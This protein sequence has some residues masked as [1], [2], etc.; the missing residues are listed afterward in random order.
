MWIFKLGDNSIKRKTRNSPH[1]PRKLQEVAMGL[2][3]EGQ[4]KRL[5]IV[6]ENQNLLGSISRPQIVTLKVLSD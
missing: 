5:K 6:P 2:V 4:R 3:S 1:S